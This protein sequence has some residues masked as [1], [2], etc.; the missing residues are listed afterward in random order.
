MYTGLLK[1]E[2]DFLSLTEFFVLFLS[3]DAK[4]FFAELKKEILCDL[5]GFINTTIFKSKEE[6]KWNGMILFAQKA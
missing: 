6:K 3:C 1:K 4:Y 2:Y 5:Q